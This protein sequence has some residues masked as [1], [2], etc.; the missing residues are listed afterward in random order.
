MDG[1][2]DP[3]AST[4][5][6]PAPAAPP[7]EP[8]RW[9]WVA[10][11]FGAAV[12][13]ALVAWMFRAPLLTRY[14][15]FRADVY[16]RGAEQFLAAGN[17]ELARVQIAN[18]IRHDAMRAETWRIA[19]RLQQAR[20]EPDYVVYL[21]RA[22][23]LEPEKSDVA[24]ALLE[25]CARLP[26][27][28]VADLFVPRILERHTNLAEVW[29]LAGVIQLSQR[30]L[31]EG[32]DCL[33][34]AQALAPQDD[35]IRLALATIELAAPQPDVAAR[36]RAALEELRN[37]NPEY[38]A[39][40]TQSLV[41]A[42]RIN[43]PQRA[44]TLLEELIGSD[45]GNWT[46]RV[47]RLDLVR[48]VRP[49]SIAREVETLWN[50]TRTVPQRLDLLARIADW[51]GPT[52]ARAYLDRLPRSERLHADVRLI[53]I[54]LLW[55]DDRWSDI[56]A[57]AGEDT[58]RPGTTPAQRVN[59]W[60]WLSRAQGK[61]GDNSLSQL[62]LRNAL[63]EAGRDAELAMNSGDLLLRWGDV[64][65]ATRFYE[66]AV[67]GTRE[68]RVPAYTKLITAYQSQ[69][70]TAGLLRCFEEL[71]RL[72]P[73]NP[74]IRNNIAAL[75]L[76]QQRD[77]PRAVEMAEANYRKVPDNPLI[78]DTYARALALSGNLPRALEIYERLPATGTNFPAVLLHRADTLRRA[79][80]TNEARQLAT[81]LTR[82]SFLPEEQELLDGL[83]APA[84]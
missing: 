63:Q 33:R 11:F 53:E 84:P 64:P 71:N 3:R 41:E 29:H 43:D 4:E 76:V 12:L 15:H 82:G 26:R 49:E 6:A 39:A 7:P 60:L 19:A 47:R 13:A 31:N 23:E 5:T 25:A 57:I 1:F 48:A 59:F 58:R 17:L 52:A 8:Q 72:V 55:R 2:P 21:A 34:R 67:E 44:L 9:K 28:D 46:W 77:L 35:R 14:H 10:G 65:G 61:L 50:N 70:N 75:L 30:R 27:F 22:Y 37:R 40:A 56:V 38:F 36:G 62:G 45:P 16:N 42:A 78:A 69:R 54:A 80:R 66:L 51:A 24:I 68:L 79:G 32:Y 74:A 20:K 83:L 18:S 81:G 73:N